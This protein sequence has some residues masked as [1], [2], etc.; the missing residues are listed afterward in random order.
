MIRWETFF[1]A[2]SGL[3]AH[4]PRSALE[5]LGLIVGAAV[6]SV[7]WACDPGLVTSVDAVIVSILLLVGGIGVGHIM[8]VSVTFRVREI[9]LYKALG[10]TDS[11]IVGQFVLEAAALAGLGGLLGVGLG[12]GLILLARA[13]GSLLAAFGAAPA[14]LSLVV[15]LPPVVAAF[16]ICIAIGAIAGGYPAYRAAHIDTVDALRHTSSSD[17]VNPVSRDHAQ[18]SWLPRALFPW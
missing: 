16:G 6:I 3:R 12:F 9:G 2:L 15:S 18:R 10:A 7:L 8:L 5:M 1:V 17:R 14:T 13:L 4:R 11:T